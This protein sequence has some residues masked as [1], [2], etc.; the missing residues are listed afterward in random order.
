MNFKV[1]DKVKGLSN[2]YGFTNTDMYLGEVK[3]VGDYSIEILVL[4]HKDSNEI[5]N[6]YT[7]YFP[8]GKF[9]IVDNLT[10]SQLQSE[11]DKLSNKVQEEYSNVIS[12]RDKVN[13]LKKQLKQLK[14]ENKKEKNKPI[15]DDVE[16]EYLSAVIRPFKNRISDIV[17]RNFDSEKSYIVIHINSESFYFPYFKKGTMYEGM[18]ADKKYTLKELCLDE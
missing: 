12:N 7:A 6:V 10:I 18:E 3:K 8:E 4:E 2:K 11:I 16:K 17:K 13:Y 14:E 9:E 15:L 1:G 5:G